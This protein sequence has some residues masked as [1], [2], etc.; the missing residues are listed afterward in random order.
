M[1]LQLELLERLEAGLAVSAGGDVQQEDGGGVE[2]AL[3]LQSPR[4]GGTALLTQDELLGSVA[5]TVRLELLL[6]RPRPHSVVVQ[7]DNVSFWSQTRL[8]STHFDPC[9]FI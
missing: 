7:G 6:G 3:T 5:D 9:Y 2:T 4:E 1:F 8:K